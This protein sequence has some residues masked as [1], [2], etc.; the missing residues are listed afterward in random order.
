[1]GGA[2][3]EDGALVRGPVVC[4]LVVFECQ[5]YVLRVHHSFMEGKARCCHSI[6][7]TMGT[8]SDGRAASMAI[9]GR[10][11]IIIVGEVVGFGTLEENSIEITHYSEVVK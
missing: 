1:M 7:V 6:A 5:G 4:G 2:D 9:R 3:P 10:G 8:P 11:V